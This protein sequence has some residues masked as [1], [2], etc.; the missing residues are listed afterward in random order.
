LEYDSI[1]KARIEGFIKDCLK[2]IL[3]GKYQEPKQLPKSLEDIDN[4][5]TSAGL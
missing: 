4:L 1:I 5:L 3:K 2:E